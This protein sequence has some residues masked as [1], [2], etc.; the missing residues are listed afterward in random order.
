MIIDHDRIIAHQIVMDNHFIFIREAQDVYKRQIWKGSSWVP[1]PDSR[2]A[3]CCL[4]YTS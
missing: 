4:L 3:A 2:R 1:A